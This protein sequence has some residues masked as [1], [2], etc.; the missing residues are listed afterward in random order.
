M[1]TH[2]DFK[3]EQCPYCQQRFKRRYDMNFHVRNQHK[4]EVADQAKVGTV[5]FDEVEAAVMGI[6]KMIRAD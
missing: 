5:R 4:T 6:K 3:P 2:I 1:K